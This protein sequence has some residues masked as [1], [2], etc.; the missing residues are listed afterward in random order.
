M[1]RVVAVPTLR[2]AEVFTPARMGARQRQFDHPQSVSGGRTVRPPFAQARPNIRDPDRC[3]AT[4]Q[5]RIQKSAAA[6]VPYVIP[7][8]GIRKR[9]SASE[10][11]VGHADSGG[12]P[13]RAAG[14]GRPD[15]E[16]NADRDG[17]GSE[18]PP[19]HML[20]GEPPELRAN[21]RAR[22]RDLRVLCRSAGIL[23]PG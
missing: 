20:E 4:S 12:T 19:A 13:W 1:R 9:N 22:N 17:D 11:T 5:Q 18:T 8:S 2:T 16:R 23:R 7:N 3:C 14:T 6:P 21:R 10:G 15:A